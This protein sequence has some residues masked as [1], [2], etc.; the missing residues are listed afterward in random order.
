MQLFVVSGSFGITVVL[1]VLPASLT[2]LEHVLRCLL[3]AGT[4]T[5]KSCAIAFCIDQKSHRRD[6][7]TLPQHV[8]QPYF[9]RRLQRWLLRLP[10]GRGPGQGCLRVLAEQWS[11]ESGDGSQVPFS[12]PGEGRQ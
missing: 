6:Y 12:L 5:S 7:P 10:L 9:R 2:T 1:H 3:I 8:F 11:L 4:P